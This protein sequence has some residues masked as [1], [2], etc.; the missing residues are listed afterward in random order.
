MI[1]D[2]GVPAEARPG[3]VPVRGKGAYSLDTISTGG[4]IALVMECFARMDGEPRR[5]KEEAKTTPGQRRPGS[6][7]WDGEEDEDKTNKGTTTLRAKDGPDQQAGIG[8]DTK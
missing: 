5:R 3:R 2:S 4:T 8:R 7:S 6:A 1:G